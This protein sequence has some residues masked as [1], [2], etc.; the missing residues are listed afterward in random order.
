MLVLTHSPLGM[1]SDAGFYNL[2]NKSASSLVRSGCQLHTCERC[3]HVP[4]RR[5]HVSSRTARRAC[6]LA[7][8]PAR[9][10]AARRCRRHR[11]HTAPAG[12]PAGARPGD[13]YSGGL[14]ARPTSQARAPAEAHALAACY[15]CATHWRCCNATRLTAAGCSLPKDAVNTPSNLLQQA[16]G[17]SGDEQPPAAGGHRRDLHRFSLSE[18]A[19]TVGAETPSTLWPVSF[20]D[21]CLGRIRRGSVAGCIWGSAAD[22][23]RRS[24][25]CCQL[26]AACHTICRACPAGHDR[27]AV[28]VVRLGHFA[29]HIR[30]CADRGLGQGR[31]HHRPGDG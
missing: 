13:L 27:R 14:C 1:S 21:A 5:P 29:G 4:W 18:P 31:Q 19:G 20:Q 17:G 24:D 30:A 8:R 26:P 9:Q 2:Y 11:C 7:R 6:Q 16:Q 15:N 23:W 25:C 3:A 10:Q 22:S 12:M 28:R